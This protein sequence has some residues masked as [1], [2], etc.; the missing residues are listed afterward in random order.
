MEDLMPVTAWK[1]FERE[2]NRATGLNA[3]VFDAEGNRITD[4]VAWANGLC[5]LIKR[6]PASAQAICSVAHQEIARQARLTRQPVVAE[7]DAGMLKICVPI[8]VGEAFVG[9]AGGCG[10]LED[11]AHLESFHISQVTEL[12]KERIAE[13]SADIPAMTANKAAATA[14]FIAGR[15]AEV[16]Q[17]VG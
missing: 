7:C 10:M 16:I 13:I 8:F 11:P 5:P 12:S 17:A 3:C 2:L 9:I 6:R 15:V 4:F 14:D 1:E